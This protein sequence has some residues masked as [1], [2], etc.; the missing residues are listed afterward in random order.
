MTFTA[1]YR[2]GGGTSGNVGAEAICHLVVPA[3]AEAGG[4]A[5]RN[6]LP[7]NGGRNPESKDDVRLVAPYAFRGE[8]ER[9]ITA[10]DYATIAARLG[11]PSLQSTAAALR[12]T[13]SWFRADIAL[14]PRRRAPSGAADPAVIAAGLERF[15]RIGHDLAT[16]VGVA[17]PLDVR[18]S[19]CAE[20]DHLRAHVRADVLDV[21]GSGVTRTGALGFFHPDA[22]VLGQ[23]IDISRVTAAAMRV[24]GVASVKVDRFERLDDGPANEI[25]TG[26]LPI[27]PLEVARLDNDP[28]SPENGVLTVKVEGGR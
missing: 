10:D 7:A 18:L 26:V 5:P 22:L 23:D 3:I 6:P 17:V 11:G 21:L 15:R 20:P 27:G 13:G 8:I 2:S 9:A 28:S 4:L 19:V 12:W 25:E 1:H 16:S 24:E 14:D